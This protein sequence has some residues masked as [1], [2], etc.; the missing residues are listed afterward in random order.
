MPFFVDGQAF[1]YTILTPS[2]EGYI[3]RTT[4]KLICDFGN[5]IHIL[6]RSGNTFEAQC[7]PL[8]GISYVEV[9]SVLLYSHIKINGVTKQGVP[10]SSTIRFNS[11]GD[12][13]FTPILKRMRLATV[14][15]KDA[16]QSSELEKFDHL[17]RLNFKFMNYAKRS[18]LAGDKVIH[19]I[20]QPEIRVPVF[21]VL[22]WT[23]YKTISPTHMSILT[24]RELITIRENEMQ[25]GAG[26]YGGIWNYIP[27]NKIVSLTLSRK[28]NDLLVLS[29]QL[30]ESV[31]L[32]YLFQDSAKQEL[33]QLLERFSELTAR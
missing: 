2:R 4:E 18:I 10:A 17:I 29:I 8:E 12:Y 20:L 32:E 22:G 16:V 14:D 27:L 6:E 1:P 33:D 25:S 28:N 3:D 9:R 24:S 11:V 23:Y 13:L 30:P 26:K 19:S 31:R 21:K 15:S 7:Y 5:E